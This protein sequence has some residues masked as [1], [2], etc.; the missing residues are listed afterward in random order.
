MIS[1]TII[2][3]NPKAMANLGV[4]RIPKA[5]TNPK[6]IEPRKA[7]DRLPS[8]PITTMMKH[9]IRMS[10]SIPGMTAD[11]GAT[12]APPNPASQDPNIKTIV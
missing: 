9:S 3:I 5:V 1:T 2:R 8:P 6:I 11:M 12:R 10:M 4:T 7:P